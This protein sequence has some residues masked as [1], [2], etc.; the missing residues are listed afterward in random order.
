MKRL[1]YTGI[2]Y[3]LYPINFIIRNDIKGPCNTIGLNQ[4]NR[5]STVREFKLQSNHTLSL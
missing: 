3:T 5:H 1:H 4:I 2:C